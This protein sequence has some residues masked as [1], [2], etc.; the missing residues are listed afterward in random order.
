MSD[1]KE[2]QQGIIVKSPQQ[3]PTFTI[4]Q[5]SINYG[6][7]DSN[8]QATINGW[9]VVVTAVNYNANNRD[10]VYV[11]T[12]GAIKTVFLPGSPAV[13]TRIRIVD[14]ANTWAAFNLTVDRNG[15]LIDGVASNLIM[16]V[17]GTWAELV[18]V[19]GIKGWKILL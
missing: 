2:I 9:N 5:G 17:S 7:L 1:Y 4:P 15:S 11:N 14:Y 19:D 18:Y 16:N 13:G 3:G 6:Q 12:T 8:L 10:E